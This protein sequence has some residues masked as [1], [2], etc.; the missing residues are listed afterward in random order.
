VIDLLNEVGQPP[1]AGWSDVE[2]TDAAR[3]D[4]VVQRWIEVRVGE[5]GG[6]GL[7]EL[8]VG[9]SAFKYRVT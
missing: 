8:V 9:D 1:D 6:I 7:D 4:E 3:V 5:D 2:A